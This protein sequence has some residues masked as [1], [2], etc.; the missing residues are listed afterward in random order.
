MDLYSSLVILV[1][2]VAAG[3][4]LTFPF[5][6]SEPDSESKP[7]NKPASYKIENLQP[8]A[9]ETDDLDRAAGKVVEKHD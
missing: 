3:L 5:I 4:L 7:K 9:D 8:P 6:K 2:A 1:V